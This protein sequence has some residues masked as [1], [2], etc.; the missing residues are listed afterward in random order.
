M[1]GEIV[2]F[3]KRS[4]DRKKVSQFNKGGLARGCGAV[5]ENKRKTTKMA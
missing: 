5:M 3:N 1:G 4:Q 2:D